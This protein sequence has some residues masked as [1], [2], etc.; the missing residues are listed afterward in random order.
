[1]NGFRQTEI[2]LDVDFA[3]S[4]IYSIREPAG[5]GGRTRRLPE[6]ISEGM[7]RAAGNRSIWRRP[8]ARMFSDDGWPRVAD[9]IKTFGC[10]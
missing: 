4:D 3:K 5:T 2:R 7:V 9:A 10:C 6:R 1:M 8:G